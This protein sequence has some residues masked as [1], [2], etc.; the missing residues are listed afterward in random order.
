MEIDKGNRSKAPE[1]DDSMKR[2][3]INK[4]W[5]K[6]ICDKKKKVPGYS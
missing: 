3:K 2:S 6:K 1:R 5:K 4:I